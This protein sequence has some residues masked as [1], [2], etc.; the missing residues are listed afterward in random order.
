MRRIAFVIFALCAGQIGFAPA[1]LAEGAADAASLAARLPAPVLKRLRAAPDRFLA[2]ALALIYASGSTEG[3]T[4]A[5]LAGHIALQR[6]GLRAKEMRRL[7]AGDLDNDGAVTADELETLAAAQSAE[8]R[9]AL[10]MTAAAADGDGDGT[11][12]A[13]ELRAQAQV[14]AL[15]KLPEAEALAV[16]AL[17]A[18]DLDG[19]DRVTALEITQSVTILTAQ[20]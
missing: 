3:A 6:A 13:V 20:G 18:F 12:S 4:E 19:N 1:T 7:L 10:R 15:K 14:A 2:E 5:D 9:G 16:T 11:I 17:I 8:A